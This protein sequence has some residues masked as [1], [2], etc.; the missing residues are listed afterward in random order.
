MKNV[1][2]QTKSDSRRSTASRKSKHKPP[3]RVKYERTHPLISARLR[4]SIRDK[5]RRELRRR[6]STLSQ[7]LTWYVERK[8][9]FLELA[10]GTLMK[11]Y[12]IPISKFE[13]ILKLKISNVSSLTQFGLGVK[14]RLD[15]GTSLP[16]GVCLAYTIHCIYSRREP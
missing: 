13:N 15:D 11:Y 8:R 5:L 6:R 10:V 9:F 2:F 14:V 4:A 12:R 7:F 16:L 1:V 3:S